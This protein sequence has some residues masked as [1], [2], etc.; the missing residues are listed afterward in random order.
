MAI[1]GDA[2]RLPLAA[3]S[4]AQHGSPRPVGAR[5]D[6]V[7]QFFVSCDCPAATQGNRNKKPDHQPHLAPSPTTLSYRHCEARS[8]VAIH[9]DAPRLPLDTTS[10]ARH[11]SPRPVGARD[12]A[13]LPFLVSCDCQGRR[14]AIATKNPITNALSRHPRQCFHTVI[15]RRAA[16]WQSMV[17]HHDCHWIQPRPRGMDRHAPLGLNGMDA[18]T[19]TGI[20]V[21]KWA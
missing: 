12:D 5:D 15:A 3:T 21:P 8:A 17:T 6:A 4:A 9:G 19:S 13:V 18:P 1:H 20:K 14:R 7:S 11:G 10:A 16:P 2:P